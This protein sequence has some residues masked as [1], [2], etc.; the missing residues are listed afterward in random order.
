MSA[1]CVRCGDRPA[2]LPDWVYCDPC[3]EV[4]D[5]G[6]SVDGGQETVQNDYGPGVGSAE[7]AKL[8]KSAPEVGARKQDITNPV[9]AKAI[10]VVNAR[11]VS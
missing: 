1:E 6:M 7:P 4:M 8:N 11:G 3:R 5:R 2:T 10:R 9:I